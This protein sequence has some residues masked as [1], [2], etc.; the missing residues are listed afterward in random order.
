VGNIDARHVTI[1]GD[2]VL[3]TTAAEAREVWR[4]GDSAPFTFFSGS[5]VSRDITVTWVNPDGGN[6]LETLP[7]L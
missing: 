3:D 6:G 2:A 7:L 4:P 5:G 1:T